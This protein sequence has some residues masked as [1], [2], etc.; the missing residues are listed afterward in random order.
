MKN[1]YHFATFI[2]IIAFFFAKP[3]YAQ[4]YKLDNNFEGACYVFAGVGLGSTN[5]KNYTDWLSTKNLPTGQGNYL[6]IHAGFMAI[7][8]KKIMYGINFSATNQTK[9]NPNAL[10]PH[11]AITVLG[12][13]GYNFL[14]V[15]R[16]NFYLMT[17]IGYQRTDIDW[18]G[19][20]PASFARP[21]ITASFAATRQD[22]FMLSPE[23][24]INY[25]I[26]IDV[27]EGLLIGL[28]VG[29]NISMISGDWKY[30]DYKSP[31]TYTK[32]SPRFVLVTPEIPKSL[33]QVFLVSLSVGYFLSW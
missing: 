24:G 31:E 29:T 15:N 3:A 21:Y 6:P 13:I 14:T 26:P 22:R 32:Y 12:K 10:I 28:T 1:Q 20:P 9:L 17:G 19:T 5:L 11:S 25:I 7:S 27:D 18:D 16:L 33:T 30:A 4:Q 2:A 23:I 8:R